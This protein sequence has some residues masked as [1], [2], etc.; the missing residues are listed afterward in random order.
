VDRF[1]PH[2]KKIWEMR[3]STC[4]LRG[5]VALIRKGSGQVVGVTEVVDSLPPLDTPVVKWNG[6][7]DER[8]GRRSAHRA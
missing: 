7:M 2:G 8:T 5:P 1:D 4:R 3:K 6:F